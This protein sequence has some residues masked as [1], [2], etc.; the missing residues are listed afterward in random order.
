M[1]IKL[2][3][4]LFLVLFCEYSFAQQE[5]NQVSISLGAASS[6]AGTVINLS[7][8]EN[9]STSPAVN[10]NADLGM[11]NK[12]SLGISYCYQNFVTNGIAYIQTTNP[13][14]GYNY[15][16]MN[17]KLIQDRHNAGVRFLFHFS[18]KKDLDIYAGLRL[19]YQF[20]QTKNDLDKSLNVIKNYNNTTD[21]L[22]GKKNRY[23]QQIVI[24]GKY[25][26]NETFGVFSELGIGFPYA[27]NV[28]LAMRLN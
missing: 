9:S 19:S 26:W 15:T 16:A 4:Y 12:F 22:G 17:Y 1:K 5:K 14:Y 23:T 2:I 25:Y 6:L 13:I 11:N 18:E 7:G 10:I 8:S 28:G 27:F 3:F 20:N 24:G 21:I